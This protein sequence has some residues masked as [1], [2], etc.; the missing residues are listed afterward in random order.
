MALLVILGI[1][2]VWLILKCGFAILSWI[3]YAIGR[4]FGWIWGLVTLPFRLLW[5][6]IK[7]AVRRSM[8]KLRNKA[9]STVPSANQNIAVPTVITSV[10][11]M[12]G[13]GYEIF[14][15]NV[16]KRLNFQDIRLT[17]TTGD[18]GADILARDPSGH[19]VCVQ[20]K[21][22][23]KSVGVRA[24]QEAC[25]ARIYY[26]CERAIVMTNSTFTPVAKELAAKTGVDLIERYL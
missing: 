16:L 15:A 2:G 10:D 22:Y 20:C 25:T 26:H 8:L 14:C 3:V 4:L 21:R 1:I 12:T 11:Q 23:S 6:S 18:F 13:Q 5:R 17:P 9:V 24:I 19:S 7:T